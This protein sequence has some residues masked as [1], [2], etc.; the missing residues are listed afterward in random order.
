MREYLFEPMELWP[1]TKYFSSLTETRYAFADSDSGE[2]YFFMPLRRFETAIQTAVLH[3]T[4]VI[5]DRR[6]FQRL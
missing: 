6:L 1:Q 3:G 2:T 4:T 5:G